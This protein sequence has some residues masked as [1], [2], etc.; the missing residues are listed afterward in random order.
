[1]EIVSKSRVRGIEL[2]ISGGIGAWLRENL[3]S[4]EEGA[5]TS[6]VGRA[7]TVLERDEDLDAVHG[8]PGEPELVS[9]SGIATIRG[10]LPASLPEFWLL[11]NRESRI[12]GVTLC[13]SRELH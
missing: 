12:F 5:F 11:A 2:A 13:L 1:M 8:V 3:G 9:S 7:L 10:T 6:A 4:A